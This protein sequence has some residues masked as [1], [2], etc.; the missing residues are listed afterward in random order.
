MCA[1]EYRS[2]LF[3]TLL[4]N[5]FWWSS[6]SVFLY[7]SRLYITGRNIS[8]IIS[9]F[10]KRS[11][12]SDRTDKH[13]FSGK[14]RHSPGNATK[15]TSSAH[16]FPDQSEDGR[17]EVDG[18]RDEKSREDTAQDRR[19]NDAETSPD[20]SND[21]VHDSTENLSSVSP[22]SVTSARAQTPISCDFEPPSD[23]PSNA[24]TTTVAESL[25]DAEHQAENEPANDSRIPAGVEEPSSFMSDASIDVV[26]TNNID[27]SNDKVK[28]T[29]AEAIDKDVTVERVASPE[30]SDRETE[31]H[32]SATAESESFLEKSSFSQQSPLTSSIFKA[33]GI[34]EPREESKINEMNEELN[35]SYDDLQIR[36]EGTITPEDID[37]KASESQPVSSTVS[38]DEPTAYEVMHS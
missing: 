4:N 38:D 12:S 10:E 19:D 36:D 37:R 28:Q 8:D 27:V 1:D 34:Q 26:T 5:F 33:L 30:V 3:F 35:D 11:R 22:I 15:S 9:N 17:L 13:L 18:K 2:L 32:V 16:F 29:N 7:L 6:H 21:L 23:L 31:D 24:A 14:R 20:K 25:I